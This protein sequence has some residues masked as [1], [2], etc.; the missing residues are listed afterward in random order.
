VKAILT[1]MA[2]HVNAP[3][4]QEHGCGALCNLA[5]NGESRRVISLEGG[6][7]GIIAAMENHPMAVAVQKNCCGALWNLARGD[8]N[9]FVIADCGGIAAITGAMINHTYAVGMLVMACGALWNLASNNGANQ[10]K[11]I[12]SG[13][14][15]ALQAAIE[16]HPAQGVLCENAMGALRSLGWKQNHSDDRNDSQPDE[17]TDALS[18]VEVS[19]TNSTKLSHPYRNSRRRSRNKHGPSMFLDVM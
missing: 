16:L 18:E 1:A 19:T 5:Y 17:W 4:V 14:Y 8:H 6:E 11:I 12:K 3:T 13:G 7:K 2:M 15:D 10:K 9:Q